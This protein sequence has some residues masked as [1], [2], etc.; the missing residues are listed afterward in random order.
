[1][2]IGIK[3]GNSTSFLSTFLPKDLRYKVNKELSFF[4]ESKYYRCRNKKLCIENLVDWETLSFPTGL[5]RRLCTVLVENGH[6]FQLFDERKRP[7]TNYIRFKQ[8]VDEFTAYPDQ[9]NAVNSFLNSP[10]GRGIVTLPTGV[11][12]TR[13]MKDTIMGLGVKTL[14]VEPGLNLKRQVS[15]YLEESLGNVQWFEKGKENKSHIVVANLDSLT[16]ASKDDLAG[17]DCVIFDEYHHEACATARTINQNLLDS[18]YYKFALT[19][20]N[21]R[22]NKSE[23]IL[24]DSVIANEL[25]SLSPVE[26]ISKGYIT[27][28]QYFVRDIP[29]KGS[30]VD[31]GPFQPTPEELEMMWE[32]EKKS[33]PYHKVYKNYIVNE[34]RRNDAIVTKAAELVEERVPTLILVKEVAHGEEL[35]SRIDGAQFVTGQND[36]ELNF[37]LLED[38][39]AGKIPVLVGTS[40]IGEGIDTKRAGAVLLGNG[41]KA[42]SR[43][44][45]NLGRVVRRF[46]GKEHG[47]VFDFKDSSH[48]TTA[49]HSRKRE[50]IVKKNFGVKAQEF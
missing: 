20:T 22:N 2:K 43:I 27:P 17:F 44:M 19:A 39:N 21:Y 12:K 29:F 4:D 18:I 25:Y 38:F 16:N 34:E 49:K 14:V 35:S 37:S 11:G 13:V 50:R 47:L 23:Q 3:I 33:M 24:L 26:A 45:Q 7:E 36:K 6:S 31:Y 15:D 5:L 28:I 40:V 9:V 48:D 30:E 42:D 1:M 8:R 41:E 10:S 46:E 32:K